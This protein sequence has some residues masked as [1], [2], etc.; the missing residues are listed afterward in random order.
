MGHRSYLVVSGTIFGAIALLHLSRLFY[1][2]PAQIGTWAVPVWVS[3]AGLVIAAVLS[4]WAF[5]LARK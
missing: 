1:Q 5:R 4:I 2:W 3:W